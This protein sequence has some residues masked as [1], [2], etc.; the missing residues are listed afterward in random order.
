MGECCDIP[1][2]EVIENNLAQ[3][4]SLDEW[5]RATW[6]IQE[7][8]LTGY[9]PR[10]SLFCVTATYDFED[11]QVPKTIPFLPPYWDGTVV[12]VYN[13]ANLDRVNGPPQNSDNMTLCARLQETAATNKLSVAPCF[14]PNYLAGPYWILSVGENATG[15]YDWAIVIG[16]EPTVPSAEG[17]TTK[18]TGTNGAGLWLFSRDPVASEDTMNAMHNELAYKGITNMSLLKVEQ[19]GCTYE[20]AFIKDGRP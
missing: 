6:Y 10:N 13:Q 4:V 19:D 9:Q 18:Q 1:V 2:C 15:Q 11:A 8:Q 12:S 14:L 7:Q 5:V 17:C 3:N 16:G 20:S